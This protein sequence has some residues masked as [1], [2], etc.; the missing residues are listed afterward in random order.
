MLK[1]GKHSVTALSRDASAKVPSGVT[2]KSVNY[3]DEA[4]IVEALKGQDALIVTMGVT[5]PPEQQ[6]KLINA[7]AKAGVKY[8][9]PNEYGYDWDD[10][11]AGKDTFLGT[12]CVPY[13]KQIEELGMSWISVACGFWY[14][15]SLAAG[16]Y[17][18]NLQD[19]TVT[20]VD[21]GTTPLTTS[22]WPQVGE[23]VAKL[24]SL[25][26]GT[27]SKFKNNFVR[28]NSF[29]LSQQEMLDSVLR[30]TGAKAEDW[31]IT[32]EPH[33]ERYN[34]GMK[35]MQSGDRSGFQRVLY[36]RAFYP[37]QPANLE[38]K[39]LDNDTLG[40]SKVDLDAATKVAVDMPPPNY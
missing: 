26:D 19:K 17:G 13:R 34:A 33:E 3:D 31:K 39:G 24:F 21:D 7:A 20:F 15:F 29:T 40:L 6:T 8:V 16:G 28:F 37:E 25:P 14:E 4:T 11:G 10:T 23:A 27:L 32:R 9:V 1:N 2:V 35:A 36:T 30:V 38:P 22:T 5:A 18:F 12:R